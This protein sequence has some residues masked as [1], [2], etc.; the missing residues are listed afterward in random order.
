MA[1]IRSAHHV[2]Q[3][4]CNKAIGGAVWPASLK[5]LK[6]GDRFNKPINGGTLPASLERLMF[7]YHFSRPIDQVARRPSLR[8][9]T[10]GFKFQDSS[11]GFSGPHSCDVSRS[12]GGPMRCCR[13]CR[14]LRSA[15]PVIGDTR[16]GR[17][18]VRWHWA[19]QHALVLAKAQA[20][21]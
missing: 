5:S 16:S 1:A 3:L 15:M 17:Y 10:F 6:F 8:Y 18:C 4:D 2:W 14:E 7:G 20:A 12:A 21:E 19:R 13:H 11:K 9:L